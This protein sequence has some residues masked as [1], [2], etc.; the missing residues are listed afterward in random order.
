MAERG[1]SDFGVPSSQK[2]GP[3][4]K[5]KMNAT[6][7]C[8]MICGIAGLSI[9]VLVIWLFIISIIAGRN[10]LEMVLDS[11]LGFGGFLGII[12]L[13]LIIAIL[14]RT[15]KAAAFIFGAGLFI[16]AAM[17]FLPKFLNKLGPTRVKIAKWQISEFENS[18]QMFNLDTKRLPATAE[19]LDALVDNPGN[20]DGWNGPYLG[21]DVPLDPWGRLY[22][23]RYPGMRNPDSYDLWSDGNDGIEGTKDDVANIK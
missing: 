14:I 2:T 8:R 11:E 3:P 4:G 18:I 10:L 16:I 6:A 9:L 1:G 12:S 7:L 17:L 21:K 13:V 5:I 15:K 20:L 23:Y 22:H 19:G